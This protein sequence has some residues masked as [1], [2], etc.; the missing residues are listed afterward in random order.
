MKLLVTIATFLG[1][2]VICVSV[3][4]FYTS[5]VL[6][7]T[8]FELALTEEKLATTEDKLATITDELEETNEALYDASNKLENL[9]EELE[10]TEDELSDTK[11]ELSLASSELS[12]I[13][14]RLVSTKNDLEDTEEQLEIARETLG[15]LGITLMAS[16]QCND[17]DLVDNPDAKNPSWAEV[18]DFLSE[19]KTEENTYIEGEY[20]CS[21]FSRDVHNN[22]E[23][24]GIRAAE[25]QVWWSNDI[26]GHALNAF[27]TT[28][29]GLVYIDC[30]GGPDAAA[31]IVMDKAYRGAE[32]YLITGENVRD[33]YWWD[34][35]WIYFYIPTSRGADAITSNIIIYW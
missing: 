11:T 27:L 21:Q 3:W 6:D 16:K 5:G 18:K 20:D 23:A 9:E 19:D 4:A 24:A 7:E 8:R 25:V 1:V 13:K 15:G 12:S 17:V 30:T 28:D 22:A 33:D 31:R 34:N 32:V 14:N 10:D 35:L 26:Y 2:A 29:Y